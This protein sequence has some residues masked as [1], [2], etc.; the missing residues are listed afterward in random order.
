MSNN[1]HIIKYKVYV[2]VLV[3]LIT[4]TLLS[5]AA[6]GIHL[7]SLTVAIALSFATLKSSLVLWYFMHLKY[8]NR[9]Y[10]LMV[11]LVMLV[12]VAVM[13]VT[14]LDYSFR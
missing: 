7:G 14:F 9:L 10:I 1:H 2:R 13:I 12:F 6:T 11:G 3:A 8:E 4:F 5:I